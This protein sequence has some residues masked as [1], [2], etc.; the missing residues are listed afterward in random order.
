MAQNNR[1]VIMTV[2]DSTVVTD[3]NHF[4]P[5]SRSLSP[6]PFLISPLFSLKNPAS[7]LQEVHVTAS[8][9]S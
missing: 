5:S 1:K 6:C 4:L 3:L 7:P 9:L 2:C 8:H